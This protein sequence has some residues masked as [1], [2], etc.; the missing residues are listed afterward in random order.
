MELYVAPENRDL[1]VPIGRALISETRTT[2]LEAQNNMPLMYG[3]LLELGQNVTE[4]S[5]LFEDTRE[6]SLPADGAIFRSRSEKDSIFEHFREPIGDWVIELDRRV[7]AT[8]GYFCHYNP[9]YGDIFMEVHEP[10]RRRGLG[11][12]LV[13]EL[14]R[15]ARYAGKTPAARCDPQNIASRNTLERAG[16]TPCGKMLSAETSTKTP[17]RV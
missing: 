4:E 16:F 11:S 2:H 1:V 14:K 10:Y 13:Q 17:P 3:M 15:V 12:Y 9:P 6:T 7:V 8:G 5:I